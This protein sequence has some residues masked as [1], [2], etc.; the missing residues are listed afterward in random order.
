M[1]GLRRAL[2]AIGGAALLLGLI[3]IPLALTSHHGGS[4]GLF[5]ATQLAIGWSFVGTGLFMWWR[6]P[7]NRLGVLM[8]AVGFTWLLGSLLAT[9]DSY[10]FFIGELFAA[11]PYGFLVQMLLSFPDGRLHSRLE[12]LIVAATWFDVTVMQWAPLPFLQFTRAHG[13]ER[14]PVNPLLLTDHK[15]VSDAL[16]RGQ[17]LI[18]VLIVVALVV[19][20]VRRSRAL[21]PTHRR[22][23]NPVIW[24][25]AL[26]LV[27][28]VA[29]LV[30]KLNGVEA[31]GVDTVYL[32]GLPLLAAVPYAFLA[33]LMQS[34]FTRAGAE[35]RLVALALN[36][37]LARDRIERDPRGAREL[38]D[39]AMAEVESATSELR[40]LARGIHPAVL[41]DRGLPAALK[42]LAGRVP[43]P[44][45][46]VETPSESL[47]ARVEIASYYVV[48]EA[49][50]NVAKYAHASAAQVCVKQVN[51]SVTVEIADDGIGGADP[52]HG[53][54]LR[55]LADR[56]AALDGRLEVDSAPGRGTTIRA[57]IP[58]A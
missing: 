35:Q 2:L 53:S 38:L 13:C 4:G 51:G 24:T 43:V 1:T 25:G 30:A 44:V 34:R 46:L 45:E 56:V 11:L 50:T 21:G 36:V 9:N 47:P 28:L 5:I 17:A 19:A 31:P 14:C 23:L 40:E 15:S 58:C 55:G 12:Q 41:S 16:D 48:A 42:A 33:G 8:T 37:R 39:E 22:A 29:A 20:L 26:A 57:H 52:G 18:A 54:G 10:L 6:R 49:L 7:E 3:T 27:V 32:L